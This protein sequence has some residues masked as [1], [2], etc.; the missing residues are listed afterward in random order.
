VSIRVNGW[1]T[2]TAGVHYLPNHYDERVR[3]LREIKAIL[4]LVR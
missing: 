1:L 3:M 2:P 4:G